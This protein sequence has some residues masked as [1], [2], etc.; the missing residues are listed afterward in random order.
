M[1][2]D[3]SFLARPKREI[4][5][6]CEVWSKYNIP[7]WFNTRIENCN[8][9]VL[10]ALKDVGL[11]RM[12]F[13]IESGNEEYRTK[14]LKRPVSTKKYLEYKDYINESNIPYSL[15][16]I[17]G[18]PFETRD[19][20]L[21]TASLIREF[22]GHDGVLISKFIPYMGTELRDIAI[23]AGFLDSNSPPNTVGY[24]KLGDGSYAL[25][26]PKPYVQEE[27]VDKLVK[28]FA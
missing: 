1:F 28:C 7:F 12:A 26:M 11:Y 22:K 20:I 16:A 13:G 5:E 6:F 24:L 18:M 15:N 25:K 3:D 21:E 17:I 8:P 19:L 10:Q 14:V 9:D 23:K 4:F 27:E 2:V